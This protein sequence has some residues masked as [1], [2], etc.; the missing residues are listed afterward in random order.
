MRES[1][2]AERYAQRAVDTRRALE[3]RIRHQK[4]LGDFAIV[5]YL[6]EG[7]FLEK[8]L[9]TIDLEKRTSFILK[10]SEMITSSDGAEGVHIVWC[11]NRAVLTH[12][13]LSLELRREFG[14]KHYLKTWCRDLFTN[15]RDDIRESMRKLL[16][17]RVQAR[18]E[19]AKQG[20]LPLDL[21]YAELEAEVPQFLGYF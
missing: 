20:A 7:V 13:L 3:D 17:A 12:R 6:A 16:E 10:N 19:Q 18:V 11:P 15:A 2:Y 14:D 1:F 4:R 8:S 9:N 5:G 21:T